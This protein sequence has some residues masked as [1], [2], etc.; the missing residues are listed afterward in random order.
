VKVVDSR[1]M[2]RIDGEAQ[3][4]FG[5]PEI[6]LMED[7]AYGIFSRLRDRIWGGRLPAGPVVFLAGKGNNGGDALA[8]ARHCYF[9]GMSNPAVILGAGE[10]KAERPAGVHL[11]ILKALGVEVVDYSAGD[12]DRR[13]AHRL[14]GEAEAL[15][16]GLLGTGLSGEVRSPLKQ[17]IL[18]CNDSAAARIAVDIPSGIGDAY[19]AGYTAFRADF[20]LT[21]Q[22]PK[23]CLY[24]PHARSFCGDIHVVP[25]VFPPQAIGQDI[26]GCLIDEALK[27][28]LLRPLEADTYKGKR[29][30][31]AAFAGSEGTTGAAWLSSTAAARSRAGL[32]TLFLDREL[33]AAN[34]PKYTSVMLRPWEGES[35]ELGRFDAL[36]VGPGWGLGERREAV[37]RALFGSGLPGV[38]D[39]DGITLL[40]RMCARAGRSAP[41]GLENRWILTPHPGEFARL[42]GLETVQVLSDP[43]PHLLRASAELEA[44]I[45]L[46]GHCSFVAGPDGRYGILDGMNPAMATGGSGDVLAGIC[47]GLLT[48]G[49]EPEEAATL[50][51]ALHGQIGQSLSA[52]RGYFLAEDMVE[53]VSSA[54]M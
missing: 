50:A 43:L 31:L 34:V 52:D 20:T 14:L 15:V 16:D 42:L 17:L 12:R 3:T 5:I 45:V 9:A 19:R 35:P 21:V 38:L 27:Q 6:V 29:G 33:Y 8:V 22:L 46:K 1:R 44:V 28:R 54:C 53:A 10:P 49:Y 36:L 24:M 23:L 18:R 47:A 26:P 25:G 32:V 7:A 39:A 48:S 30:H 41:F 51:V 13:R 2:A 4:R 37:L 40:A 11:K